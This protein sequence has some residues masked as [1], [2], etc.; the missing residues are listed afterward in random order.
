M[1]RQELRFK[2]IGLLCAI[3]QKVSDIY[4]VYAQKIPEH[5]DFWLELSGEEVDHVEMI[6]ELGACAAFGRVDYDG[7]KFNVGELESTLAWL[8]G[9]YQDAQKTS[10]AMEGALVVSIKIERT[11]AESNC[12][13]A[14]I[15]RI[16]GTSDFLDNMAN[17]LREHAE[18]VEDLL[19]EVT[20]DLVIQKASKEDWKYIAEKIDK[21]ALDGED[22]RWQDFFAIKSGGRI[23]AFGRVI[24]RKDYFEIG[25]LGVDYYHRAKGVGSKMLSFLTE[26]AGRL[27]PDKEIYGVTHRTGFIENAGF[28]EVED[29][30]AELVDKKNNKCLHPEKIHIMKFVKRAES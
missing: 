13:Q 22:V 6:R 10:P 26:E 5:K 30:P 29:P 20:K 18:R 25:S 19:S 2:V 9:L 28:R 1:D 21:Y 12:Y 27:D 16:P 11:I 8:E 24:D 4:A 7:E 17:A 14:F 23:L 3:E 15:P